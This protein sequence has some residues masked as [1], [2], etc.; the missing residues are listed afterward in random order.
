MWH[1]LFDPLADAA[2][3]LVRTQVHARL[4]HRLPGD[5]AAAY[6]DGHRRRPATSRSRSPARGLVGDNLG[7]TLAARPQRRALRPGAVPVPRAA[8]RRARRA[9]HRHRRRAGARAPAPRAGAAAHPRRARPGSSSRLGVAEALVVGVARARASDSG[10]PLVVGALGVRHGRL[11][12]HD[13][14]R[15]SCWAAAAAARRHGHRRRQPSPLPALARRP[16]LTRRRRPRRRSGAPRTRAGCGCGLDIILL[17]ARRDRVL[18]H[19]R[20]G[21]KLVLA[22]E[23]VPTISVSYWAFAGPALLWVGAGLLTYRLADLL[24]SG[25]AG[26]ARGAPAP[27]RRRPR[28]HRGRQPAAPAPTARARRRARGARP[29]RSPS[30][31][32]CSTPPTASRPRSTP[33]SPTAPTSPSRRHPGRRSP[34]TRRGRRR[35]PAIPGVRH[36]EPIQH[37]FAYVGADLQDLYGVDPATIVDA[38]QLQ[39]AYFHGGTARQLVGDARRPARQRARVAP[40][41]STTSSST[42]ATDHAAP[43]GRARRKQYIDVPFHYAGVVKEFPTAPERQLP[44]RQRRLRR[45]GDR[46]RRRR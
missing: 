35:S 41:P 16:A 37:R 40:R 27:A 9:A 31:P 36:V 6:T 44:R 33:C 12:R 32:P 23:G 2:P 21:Y 14:A 8:R 34:R 38:G 24:P 29:S 46:E 43:P 18:A 1:E 7:A 39:D 45:P 3:D 15:R 11:R 4:D 42:P 25:A 17:G 13:R 19:R 26:R 28:G 30:R 10:S 20:N 22:V 5:P